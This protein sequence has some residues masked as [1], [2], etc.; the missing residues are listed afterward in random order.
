MEILDKLSY[1]D[2]EQAFSDMA[3]ATMWCVIKI[4]N[5]EYS[6]ACE[7]V[8]RCDG[9]TYDKIS[10]ENKKLAAQTILNEFIQWQS[11]GSLLAQSLKCHN[12]KFI[13]LMLDS[14]K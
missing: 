5:L 4:F 13:Q 6:R 2:K 1:T 12:N 8:L 11:S 3:Q 9:L 14:Y 10:G 7:K